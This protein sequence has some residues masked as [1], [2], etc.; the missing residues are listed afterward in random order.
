MKKKIFYLNF[1]QPLGVLVAPSK[2]INSLD[3]LKNKTVKM[4]I[5]DYEVVT[6]DPIIGHSQIEI[7]KRN[8]SFNIVNFAREAKGVTILI[9]KDENNKIIAFSTTIVSLFDKFDKKY[10]KNKVFGRITPALDNINNYHCKNCVCFEYN[11]KYVKVLDDKIFDIKKSD[12][13]IISNT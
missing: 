7:D 8:S 2:Y 9:A 6:F 10:G 3:I 1:N 12:S 11:L 5:D 4:N 13:C